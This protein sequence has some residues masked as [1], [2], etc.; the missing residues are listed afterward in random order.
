MPTGSVF[1]LHATFRPINYALMKVLR[2][3]SIPYVF[4]PHNPF[5]GLVLKRRGVAKKLYAALFE[6]QVIRNAA[7]VHALTRREVDALLQLGACKIAVV[8]NAIDTPDDKPIGDSDK[9]GVP[10]ICFLGRL[11]PL[12]KGI[13][14]MLEALRELR[15]VHGIPAIFT[16]VGPGE[17]SDIDFIKRKC[18]DLGLVI[19]ESVILAGPLF[20]EEKYNLLRR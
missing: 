6:R 20:G 3:N 7:T 9:Y 19:G 18:I 14:W 13:D 1:H 8:P 16:L 4:T 5:K 2:S 15:E 11:E 17:D 12:Q 10:S